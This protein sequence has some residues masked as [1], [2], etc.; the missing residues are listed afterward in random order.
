M[1]QV[2][3]LE[4]G[5]LYFLYRPRGEI[6]GTE[7]PVRGLGAIQRFHLVLHPQ[8]GRTFRELTIGHKELP[9]VES[10][11][12]QPC[13][14]LVDRMTS[15]A[16]EMRNERSG[17][18]YETKTRGEREQPEV[19]PAGEGVDAIVKHGDHTHLAYELE[20]PRRPQQVQETLHIE[21]EA[22]YI[23]SIKILNMALILVLHTWPSRGNP[24]IP[25][26]YASGCKAAALFR[27]ILLL[28]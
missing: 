7:E 14:G 8:P 18:R 6:P 21:E 16:E 1:A 13:W 20:L 22:S 12:R 28:F 10:L 23:L 4:R 2:Q 24:N 15:S 17:G 26:T 9:S 19:R 3:M 5:G 11:T 25:L 27:L